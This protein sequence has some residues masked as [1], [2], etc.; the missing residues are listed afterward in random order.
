MNEFLKLNHKNNGVVGLHCHQKRS[1]N[2]DSYDERITALVRFLARRAAEED[3]RMYLEALQP[4]DNIQ[5]G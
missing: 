4:P 1:H 3:Y 2:L 5:G